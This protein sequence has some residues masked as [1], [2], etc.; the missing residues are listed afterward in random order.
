MKQNV[1]MCV[2]GCGWGWVCVCV[3]VCWF[4]NEIY[5]NFY[6]GNISCKYYKNQFVTNGC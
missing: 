5:H 4:T 6:F 2:G 3:C 1:T